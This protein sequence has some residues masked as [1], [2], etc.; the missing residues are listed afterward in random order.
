MQLKHILLNHR[1]EFACV[2]PKEL[3]HGQ[4]YVINLGIKGSDFADIDLHDTEGLTQRTQQLLQKHNAVI[5]IGRYAENRLIY[6]RSP[7]FQTDTNHF[8][9]IHLGIDLMVP[10]NTPV[11]APL[12]GII[13]SFKDNGKYGDYGPTIILE[14]R[15]DD[16]R[17]FT[18]YGH[19]SRFSLNKKFVQQSID[20]GEVFAEVGN[21]QEN[22]SWPPHLHFQII[23]D[24]RNYKG[25]FP[26]VIEK[27][28]KDEFMARCPNPNLILNINA[29]IG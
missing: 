24:M 6:Q 21:T 7:L 13:H 23:D 28:K 12:S 9:T 5:G 3:Q 17:F 27:E 20:Q 8:R 10:A 19:L 16:S 25:D 14:H 26:G 2:L 4:T 1:D 18:L 22:G 11:S 29:L 15:L